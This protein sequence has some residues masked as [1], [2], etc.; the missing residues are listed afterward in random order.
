MMDKGGLGKKPVQKYLRYQ[1]QTGW[2]ADSVRC[3]VITTG[4]IRESFPEVV[5]GTG[6]KR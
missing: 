1:R 4:K 5:A 3:L 6:V 2:K